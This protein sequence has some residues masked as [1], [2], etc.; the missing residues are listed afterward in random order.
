MK[1]QEIIYNFIQELKYQEDG[2][3]DVEILD[4]LG[5]N[6]MSDICEYVVEKGDFRDRNNLAYFLFHSSL[7]LKKELN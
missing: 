2:S 4:K 5:K 7:D 1:R 3:F 6:N